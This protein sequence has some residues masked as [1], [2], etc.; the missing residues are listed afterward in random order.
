M[1]TFRQHNQAASGTGRC[2]C[3]TCPLEK[4]K[5]ALIGGLDR[6]EEHYRAAFAEL[7]AELHFHPGH[8]A[9]AGANRLRRAADHADIVVFIT[10]INSHNALQVVKATCKKSGKAFVAMRETG[11]KRVS[12]ALAELITQ[13]KE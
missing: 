7:G 8:C 3:R 10:T 5:V 9:G 2:D 1:E 11:P 6:L 4:L 12:F 13:Q